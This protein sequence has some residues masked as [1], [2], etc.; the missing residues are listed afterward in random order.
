MTDHRHHHGVIY[1]VERAGEWKWR[2]EISP[3]SCVLGLREQ[4][5]EV[6]GEERD[7]VRAAEAAIERQTSA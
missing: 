7:A 2:W 6:A 5:G 3:P 1:S 4:S